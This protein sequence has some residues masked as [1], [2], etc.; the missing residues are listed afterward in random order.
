MRAASHNLRNNSPKRKGARRRRRPGCPTVWTYSRGAA[1]S[2]RSNPNQNVSLLWITGFQPQLSWVPPQHLGANCTYEVFLKTKKGREKYLTE[3][4]EEQFYIVM[5]G[6]FLNMSVGTVCDRR[7]ELAWVSVD[8]AE[9]VRKLQCFIYSATRTHCSWQKAGRA[10]DLRFFY[11][12]LNNNFSESGRKKVLIRECSSYTEVRTGC[13]LEANINQSIHIWFNGTVNNTVATN[14]FKKDTSNDV[15][16]PAL[17]WT[18]TKTQD[19]FHISWTPP[20]I[21]RRWKF[22]IIYTECSETKSITVDGGTSTE[23]E[24]VPHCPYRMAMKAFI[25][26][27]KT[28]FSDEV[29]FDSDPS[30]WLYAAIIIPVMFAGLAALV[31]VCCRKNKEYMF[32]KVPEPRDLLSNISD[33]NN[34]SADHTLCVPAEEDDNCRISLVVDPLINKLD[35]SQSLES[36]KAPEVLCPMLAQ[37]KS[38]GP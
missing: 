22:E 30:A 38:A 29:Y 3:N 12:L 11:R 4:L 35:A 9:L 27:G 25:K 1:F 19:K 20:E 6:G 34:K 13:D 8:N 23:L 15:R 5:E 2:S 10:R 14:T 36:A 18:V 33:N 24:R 17:N 26:E 37:Q 16:L 32:P 21:E 31:L 7:S 28:P